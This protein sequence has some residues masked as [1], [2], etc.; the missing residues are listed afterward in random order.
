MNQEIAECGVPL[1][2]RTADR[3]AKKTK[4]SSMKLDG[5]AHPDRLYLTAL[6]EHLFPFHIAYSRLALVHLPLRL[7]KRGGAE[8]DI[9]KP[10]DGASADWFAQCEELWR[11]HRTERNTEQ[12]IRHA[13]YLNWLHKMTRQP[14]DTRYLVLHNAS[15]KYVCA[16]MLDRKHMPLH[17]VAESDTYY[18]SS[19]SADECRFFRRF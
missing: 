13:D 15:G 16:A 12:N 3:A 4:W 19:D 17:F 10:G 7:L 8:I 14:W 18:Y 2:M 11:S 5:N 9:G 1:R 6:G